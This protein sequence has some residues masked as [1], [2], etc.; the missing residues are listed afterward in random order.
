MIYVYYSFIPNTPTRSNKCMSH[1]TFLWLCQVVC[2]KHRSTQIQPGA[3]GNR[4]HDPN[5]C[6]ALALAKVQPS[7]PRGPSAKLL[8]VSER[9]NL[10]VKLAVKEQSSKQPAKEQS[11]QESFGLSSTDLETF[12]LHSPFWSVHRQKRLS[13]C[14]CQ[15]TSPACHWSTSI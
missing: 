12:L 1:A 4:S 8:D 6:F 14:Q 10:K 7:G 9:V 3:K 15:H 11:F 5:A 2:F 13:T